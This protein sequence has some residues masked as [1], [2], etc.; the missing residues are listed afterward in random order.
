VAEQ[1]ADTPSRFILLFQAG[2]RTHRVLMTSARSIR[3]P[4]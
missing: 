4:T 3:L 2:L 1:S